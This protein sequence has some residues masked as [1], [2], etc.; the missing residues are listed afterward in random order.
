MKKLRAGLTTRVGLLAFAATLPLVAAL[1]LLQADERNDEAQ[2][3]IGEDQR[4]AR[5]AA[6]EASEVVADGQRLVS[7]IANA[8]RFVLARPSECS[9]FLRAGLANR[10]GVLD[11]AILDRSGTTICSANSVELP[12]TIR[13]ALLD[14][15]DGGDSSNV[16]F[17]GDPIV[18]RAGGS[19]SVMVAAR[20]SSSRVAL[21][22][23]GVVIATIDVRAIAKSFS[24][25]GISPGASLFLLDR[26]N[27]IVAEF[28]SDSSD[29]GV[30][31]PLTRSVD[32]AWTSTDLRELSHPGGPMLLAPVR[33]LGSRATG[34]HVVLAV[35]RAALIAPADARWRTYMVLIVLALAAAVILG[36]IAAQQLILGPTRELENVARR[37]ADGDLSARTDIHTG[38]DG[39]VDLADAIDQVASA[40][41]RREAERDRA[42]ESLERT[43]SQFE[44]LFDQNPNPMWV[45]DAGSLRFLMVNELAIQR[46]GYSREEFL[47]MSITDIR[48]AEDVERCR[49]AARDR[50][51]TVVDG[52]SWRHRLKSGKVVDVEITS[53]L[54]TFEQRPAVLVCAR[55]I[56]ARLDAERALTEAEERMRYA[57]DAANVG[58]WE[59]NLMTG[60]SHWSSTNEIMHGLAPGSFGHSLEAFLAA[61]DP[62]DREHA[63]LAVTEA[64]RQRIDADLEYH[65][66]A[67]P[68]RQLR[69][70]GRFT[71]DAEGRPLRG[72]GVTVDVSERREMEE[73]LRHAQKLEAVGQLAGGVAHDFNN[74]LT[75]IQG[76]AEMALASVGDGE[77][78]S[79]IAEIVTASKRAAQ[80]TRQLLSFSRKQVVHVVP[81]DV[82]AMIRGLTPMLGRLIEENIE[83]TYS[84]CPGQPAVLADRGELEQALINLVV[85]ARD[86][87]PDGGTVRIEVSEDGDEQSATVSIA[88]ADTGSGMPAHVLSR[89]FEPFFTTKDPG[90]GTGLG[91]ASVYGMVKQAGGDVNIR[92]AEGKGTRVTLVFPRAAERPVNEAASVVVASGGK[93]TILLV[94]DQDGVRSFA[95]RVL[96]NGGYHVLEATN[97]TEAMNVSS[98]HEGDIA[99][100]FSD[101]VMPGPSVLEAIDRIRAFRP[102][103]AL[104]MTSGYPDAEVRSRLGRLDAHLLRK[105]FTVNELLTQ[106][107]QS[108]NRRGMRLLTVA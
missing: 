4:I 81:V 68:R 59:V 14:W 104:L 27:R 23:A 48:P 95:A 69:S 37:I 93:A 32:T 22:G 108:I 102:S 11:V 41:A 94:E 53:H 65:P 103:I 82:D 74:L 52:T 77:A 72:A 91:L 60:F 70:I 16:V 34:Y 92:S 24:E 1:F 46:Y 44:L 29:L 3:A 61:V 2:R 78:R 55:D 12:A 50:S 42:T 96:R 71:Y 87:Q 66:S 45:Y 31:I 99:L 58:V 84:G 36:T 86:A 56:S 18:S 39:I 83:L 20:V 40:V 47:A 21:P 64:I 5:I 97:A 17:F 75:V 10:P 73:H 49:D 13:R 54:V 30:R 107:E 8:Q 106:V 51:A 38:M 101:V 25:Q 35:D 15:F 79:D 85:N 105:P 80:L 100:L 26:Q 98:S 6:S 7:T 28:P 43:K 63:E 57:L 90:K 67:D 9:A 89:A 76:N 19:P 88:V 33:D 62:A